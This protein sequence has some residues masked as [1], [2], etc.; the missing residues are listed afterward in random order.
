[1]MKNKKHVDLLLAQRKG[2]TFQHLWL[3][4]LVAFVTITTLP[5]GTRA[6]SLSSSSDTQRELYYAGAGG[7]SVVAQAAA[8]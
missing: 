4:L 3:L 8:R 1:M 2:N 6:Q 7:C 5:S